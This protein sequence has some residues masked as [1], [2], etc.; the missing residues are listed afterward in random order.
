[1]HILVLGGTRFLGRA[2]VDA[3]LGRGDEVTLFNRGQSNPE[4]YP[5]LKKII[6]DRAGDLTALSSRSWDAVV[7]VAAYDPDLVSRSVQAL[8]V[9]RALAVGLTL[10]PVTETLCDTLAWDLA[11]GGPDPAVEG[12]AADQEQVLLNKLA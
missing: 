11:R 9:R 5:G 8:A 7:D 4:L 3:A 2:V 6:G 1:M 12:L 10:R